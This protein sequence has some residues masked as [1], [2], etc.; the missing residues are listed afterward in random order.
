MANF[1]AINSDLGGGEEL[2]NSD[3]ILSVR[4]YEQRESNIEDNI[5]YCL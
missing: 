4:R 1:V 5:R 3:M 2:L